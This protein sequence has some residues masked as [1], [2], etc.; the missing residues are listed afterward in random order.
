MSGREGIVGGQ[1][2][3]AAGDRGESTTGNIAGPA[4]DRSQVGQG[5]NDVPGAARNSGIGNIGQDAIANSPADGATNRQRKRT[6]DSVPLPP[7]D[8][9]VVGVSSDKI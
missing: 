3:I 2:L 1:I 7:G 6:S 8:C 4:A 5:L 9:A